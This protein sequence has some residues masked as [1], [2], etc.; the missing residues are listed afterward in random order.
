MRRQGHRGA[1]ELLSDSKSG[2]PGSDNYKVKGNIHW[3][4]AAT[5]LEAEVRLY[6]RLFTEPQPDAGGKDFKAAAQPERAGNRHRLPGAG[7]ER[8]AAALPDQRFQ[9]ERH[10][11]F[12]PPTASIP[13]ST[14]GQAGVQPRHHAEGQL[15]Q[16]RTPSVARIKSYTDLLRGT[17]SLFHTSDPVTRKQFRHYVD[18]LGMPRYFPAVETINFAQ[19]FT[20]SERD[21][22]RA[23]LMRQPDTA[24]ERPAVRDQAARAP[25]R[26]Q[27]A[28]LHRTPDP[29]A[30][31]IGLDLRQSAGAANLGGAARQRPADHLGHADCGHVGPEAHR[32]GACACRSTARACPPTRWNSGALAFRRLG[33]RR[34][35]RRP[36]D[37]GRARRACRCACAHDPGR[38]RG[39]RRQASA[40]ACCSTP[41]PARR[42]RRRAV[43]AAGRATAPRCR[44]TSMAASGVP[45]SAPTSKTCTPA[46]KNTARGWHASPASAARC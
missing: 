37:A 39:R 29:G 5:A 18:G 27:R 46:L 33:R 17:G 22:V 31:A 9:F 23:A 1:R 32:P 45:P 21:A 16:V 43:A 36:A 19:S 6:D 34:L 14:A 35:Q 3:V 40:A 11:Y 28:D 15:G 12:V 25:R 13:L 44:S 42:N 38:Q 20:D 8:A 30:K 10:G 26:I 24:T 7:H 2:T 41:A 4:S